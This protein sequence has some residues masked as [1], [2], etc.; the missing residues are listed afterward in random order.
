M[1]S[2]KIYLIVCMFFYV[3]IKAQGCS[4]AG[5]CSIN[6]TYATDSIA[7]NAIEISTVFGAGESDVTY[8]SPYVSYTRNFNKRW[9]GS[10]KITSSFASGSFGDRGSIGD[11]FLTAHYKT[12]SNKVYKWS[13]TAGLKIPFNSSNLKINDHPL[14]LDYQSSLGTF[15]FIGSVNLTYKKLDFI[16][17]LQLPVININTNSYIA[18]YSGTTDFPTT[19]LFERKPDVLF[20]TTYTIETRNSKFSFK[21]NVLFIYHLGEDTYEDIYGVRQAIKGSEGLTINGNL[22]SAYSFK[23]GSLELSLATPFVVRD[24]RPDGLTRKY[25]IGIGYKTTF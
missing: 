24:V 9:S 17:A 6:N 12:R 8:I 25:T 7:K 1:K 19:N 2:K 16:S 23:G 4:D 5:V 3:G 13:Y 14:P 20:R 11:A 21:P 18:E 10:A 22:I 15:D